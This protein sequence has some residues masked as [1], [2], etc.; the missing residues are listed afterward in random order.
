MW[1][2]R[3]CCQALTRKPQVPAAGSQMRSPGLRIEHLHHH[4]DD[5]ARRAEL[6]VLPAVL[7]LLSR[8]S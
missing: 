2:S 8:Y 3:M 7:S 1:V 6:A 5:V 4:A